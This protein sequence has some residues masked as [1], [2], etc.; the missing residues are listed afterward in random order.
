MPMSDYNQYI[1]LYIK[2]QW[3]I[4]I[5]NLTY[6]YTL[7]NLTEIERNVTAIYAISQ[8]GSNICDTQ[9]LSSFELLIRRVVKVYLRALDNTCFVGG[10]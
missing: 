6:I 9:L 8:P 4:L 1:I 2:K 10:V 3:L 5:L 7:Y